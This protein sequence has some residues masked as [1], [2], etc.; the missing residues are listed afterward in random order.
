MA[1]ILCCYVLMLW[2]IPALI[3][4]ATRWKSSSKLDTAMVALCVLVTFVI[5]L[6]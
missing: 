4:V 1:G 5:V 6:P 3:L 2:L